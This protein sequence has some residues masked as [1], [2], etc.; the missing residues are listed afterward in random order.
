MKKILIISVI[1]CVGLIANAQQIPLY[2]QYMFNRYLLNPAV[3][4]SEEG[5]NFML[6]YRNQWIG[7]EDA[8]KTFYLSYHTS[9]EEGKQGRKKFK[10]KQQKNNH[11]FGSFLFNDRTG[12]TSRTG[13]YASYAYH[14]SLDR[15][16]RA[17]L[18]TFI[19]AMQYAI[20]AD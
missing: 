10:P 4:G 16:I 7:F 17:S 15:D 2:S 3:G 6:G 9:I 20:H 14:I 1:L 19:G 5:A 12:P 13:G 11:G 18:G 8:P